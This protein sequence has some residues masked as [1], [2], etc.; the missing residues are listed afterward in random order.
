MTYKIKSASFIIICI[1]ILS[2]SCKQRDI[3]NIFP[4]GS[5]LTDSVLFNSQQILLHGKY[6]FLKGDLS[7]KTGKF[8]PYI[9]LF[10]K[11]LVL[12]SSTPF[13][14]NRIDSVINDTIYYV[15][16]DYVSN[17]FLRGQ[18]SFDRQFIFKE[19]KSPPAK[20]GFN[21]CNKMVRSLSFD[22]KTSEL[23]VVFFQ[24]D[25][26]TEGVGV[27][28]NKYSDSSFVK[29]FDYEDSLTISIEKVMFDFKKGGLNHTFL[30]NRNHR[31]IFEKMIVP[32]DSIWT[33]LF[34]D[35]KTKRSTT[36]TDVG[37]CCSI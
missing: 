29:K 11:N 18:K 16:S 4:I 36:Q 10:D 24:S 12:K 19:T 25:N 13:S 32:S 34:E 6:I 37:K 33:N 7:E 31:K 23:K 20:E 22:A 21:V 28:K 14:S 2:I 5:Q 9:L 27:E 35:I 26:L 3:S 17:W 1:S 8:Q 15:K 30:D